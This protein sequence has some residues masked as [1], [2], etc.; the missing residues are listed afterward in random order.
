MFV[1]NRQFSFVVLIPAGTHSDA[2]EKNN[3]QGATNE[4]D[5]ILR[6]EI[7]AGDVG[8]RNE[9]HSALVVLQIGLHVLKRQ[10]SLYITMIVE[11]NGILHGPEDNAVLLQRNL[12]HTLLVTILANAYLNHVE[13]TGTGRLQR[14]QA[15]QLHV[16]LIGQFF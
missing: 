8:R 12:L 4:N 2:K 15:I 6:R 14:G 11:T 5:H 13:S 9:Q 7:H 16:L 1:E 10:G 3:G